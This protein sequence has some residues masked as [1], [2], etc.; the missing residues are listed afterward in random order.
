MQ[1]AA[2]T[3]WLHELLT[4][5]A[6]YFRAAVT[7]SGGQ[8][9][10]AR[11]YNRLLSMGQW[12][13]CRLDA[14]DVVERSACCCHS[15]VVHVGEADLDYSLMYIVF[16]ASSGQSPVVS[17]RLVQYLGKPVPDEAHV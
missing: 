7:V 16:S 1:V 3:G 17:L 13:S 6:S 10:V 9:Q 11:E 14:G 2:L 4:K 8:V 5:P 12:V 15:K